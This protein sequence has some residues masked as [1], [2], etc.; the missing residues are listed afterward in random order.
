MPKPQGEP[1]SKLWLRGH[2]IPFGVW[3]AGLVLV[4]WV[5]EDLAPPLFIPV[6][7]AVKS[8]LCAVLF[9]CWKPWRFYDRIGSQGLIRGILAGFLVAAIWILPETSWVSEGF[10]DFYNRW[11]ILLPGQYP[12]FY[13]VLPEGHSSLQYSPEVCGWG[14]TLFK[15][16]G[17]AFVIAVLEEYFFRGFLYRWL[18]GGDAWR[19]P[20]GRFDVRA[21]W[22]T[23]LVFGFEHDRWVGGL[24]A[25]LV[26]GWLANRKGDLQGAVIAHV[27]TNFVLGIYVIASKQ[28]GFW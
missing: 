27:V 4:L 20:L 23:V 18:Q 25:G 5:P 13:P 28:Y 17:S 12:S 22:L 19:I 7:Y 26:Y 16:A 21:F 14:L 9:I 3:I 8:V 6:V 10:R 11:L 1:N 24:F 15:L 2:T